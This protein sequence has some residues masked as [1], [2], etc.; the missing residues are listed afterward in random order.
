[1]PFYLFFT[2]FFPPGGGFL[3]SATHSSAANMNA[4]SP[5]GSSYTSRGR[6]RYCVTKIA[7]F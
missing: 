3:T 6:I 2:V 4:R 1:M 5:R 7:R